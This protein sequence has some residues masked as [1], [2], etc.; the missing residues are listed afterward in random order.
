MIGKYSVETMC[1]S[2]KLLEPYYLGITL[3]KKEVVEKY[4]KIF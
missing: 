2:M 3:D 1:R 4:N